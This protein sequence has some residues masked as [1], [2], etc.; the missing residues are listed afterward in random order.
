MESRI[1]ELANLII[2]LDANHNVLKQYDR[3]K[4]PEQHKLYR[5]PIVNE[6]KLALKN[7]LITEDEAFDLTFK[8]VC[9]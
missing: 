9:N 1:I 6:I 5:T 4:Q 8:F 2:F 3:E 7:G